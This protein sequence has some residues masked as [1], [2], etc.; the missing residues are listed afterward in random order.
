MSILIISCIPGLVINLFKTNTYIDALIFY[1]V[2][3]VINILLMKK[4]N[5]HLLTPEG[6]KE[7]QKAYGLKSYIEDF[8]LMKEREL[9]STILWDDYLTY[10][11]AFGISNKV[12]DRFDEEFMNINIILQK[13]DKFLRF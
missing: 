11:I 3:L 1:I 5:N 8:S 4:A 2:L 12:T 10:A 7:Y 13:I 9:D 6:R